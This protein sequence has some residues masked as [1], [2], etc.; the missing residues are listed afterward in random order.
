M[1]SLSDLQGYCKER[2]ARPRRDRIHRVRLRYA[3]KVGQCTR[4]EPIPEANAMNTVPTAFLFP[5][6]AHPHETHPDPISPYQKRKLCARIILNA[7]ILEPD[8]ISN[9]T[10]AYR[11]KPLIIGETSLPVY[12]SI[13]EK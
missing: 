13:R 5:S 6:T 12:T 2:S 10:D 8:T 3:P 9:T 1:I 7:G 4:R 11:K